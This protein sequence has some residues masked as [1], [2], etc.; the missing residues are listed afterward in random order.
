MSLAGGSLPLFAEFHGDG[1]PALL[2]TLVTLNFHQCGHSPLPGVGGGLICFPETEAIFPLPSGLASLFAR[3]FTACMSVTQVIAEIEALPTAERIKVAEETLRR[4]SAADLKTV[5]RTLRRLAHPDVPEEV[6]HGY[7]DY[8][9][10]RRLALREEDIPPTFRRSMADAL[11]GH[12]VD[13]ETALRE[14]P[15]TRRE[16]Q[17]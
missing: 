1:P 3:L 9:D 12:G 8:E 6:W 14:E 2:S 17:A 13:M 15:P 11:A 4:L 7:E 16:P 10:E 5:E